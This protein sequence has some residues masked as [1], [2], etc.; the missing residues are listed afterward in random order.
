MAESVY[1]P[2]VLAS[3]LVLMS[4]QQLMMEQTLR[5]QIADLRT[6]LAHLSQEIAALRSTAHA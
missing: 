4:N 3:M 5:A 2:E 1:S 6:S